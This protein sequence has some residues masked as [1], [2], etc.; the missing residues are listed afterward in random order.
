M[1]LPIGF[2]KT[3]FYILNLKTMETI[4]HKF[5][6]HSIIVFQTNL[7]INQKIDYFV[8]NILLFQ[9][10]LSCGMHWNIFKYLLNIIKLTVLLHLNSFI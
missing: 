9:N 8:K 4:N 7:Q 6:Y 3:E 5:Y 10:R 2:S 1:C